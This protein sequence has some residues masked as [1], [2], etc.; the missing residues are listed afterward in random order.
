MKTG[1]F[2]T[3]PEQ[4]QH[5]NVSSYGLIGQLKQAQPGISCF[6]SPVNL[7]RCLRFNQTIIWI[8][9]WMAEFQERRTLR[10]TVKELIIAPK[11]IELI[12]E[13]GE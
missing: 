11:L 3:D 12:I 8:R 4:L 10:E 1:A 7:L 2:Q 5:P 6:I 13:T 9:T